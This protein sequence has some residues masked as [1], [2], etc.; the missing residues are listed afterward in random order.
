MVCKDLGGECA[1]KLSAGTPR[2]MVDTMVKHVMENHP[3]TAKAMEK[4]HNEDPDKW[5]NEFRQ[6]WALTTEE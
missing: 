4:M 1:E 6:K 3:N 5:G 2:E